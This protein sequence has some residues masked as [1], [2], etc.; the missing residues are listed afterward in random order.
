MIMTKSAQLK[1][2]KTLDMLQS[3]AN[4]HC[5]FHTELCIF[6][7]TKGKNCKDVLQGGQT[8][9][10]IFHIEFTFKCFLK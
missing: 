5:K 1:M 6:R 4:F 3:Y 2:R 9:L 7:R 10:G 8:P